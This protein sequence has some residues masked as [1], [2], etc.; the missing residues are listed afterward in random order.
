MTETVPPQLAMT[1][2][3]QSD[4]GGA[5][6][7]Y[8]EIRRSARLQAAGGEPFEMELSIAPAEDVK[9]VVVDDSSEAREAQGAVLAPKAHPQSRHT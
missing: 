8:G 1:S 9:F 5:R 2:R 7:R 6:E 3:G 4:I